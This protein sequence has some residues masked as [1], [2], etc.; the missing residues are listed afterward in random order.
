LVLGNGRAGK[1]QLVNRWRGPEFAYQPEWDS[2]HGVQVASASLATDA[3]PIRLH[4]WDFGGQDIYHGTHALF[5]R[6]RAVTAVV[7]ASDTEREQS[8]ER[9][10]IRFRNHPL[11]YW[12]NYVKHQSGAN[13]PLLIVQS[14]CSTPDCDVRRPAFDDMDVAGLSNVKEL[15]FSALKNRGRAALDDALREAAAMLHGAQRIPR[16]GLDW[17]SCD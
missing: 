1:T 4:V 5:T 15:Q 14:K 11:R 12:L 8:Y 6:T 7:W 10:G 13:N 3:A 9:D 17:N 16:L 2:T